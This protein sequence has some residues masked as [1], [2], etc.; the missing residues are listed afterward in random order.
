MPVS[1]CQAKGCYTPE[2]SPSSSDK[3]SVTEMTTEPGLQST[4]ETSCILN[5]LVRQTMD[6]VKY[7]TF[8]TN[9]LQLAM[10]A[11]LQRNE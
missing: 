9:S 8:M 5:I 1:I 3:L 6:S 11:L 10:S 2:Y 4:P 7:C